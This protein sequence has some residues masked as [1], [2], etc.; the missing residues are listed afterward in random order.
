MEEPLGKVFKKIRTGKKMSLKDVSGD[1]LSVSF[2]SKFE[3]GESDITLTRF[4]ML[5]N[6]L[7]VSIEEFYKLSTNETPS[8]NEQLIGKVSQAYYNNNLLA[9]KK[10][11]DDEFV[12]YVE[13]KSKKY[14]YNSIMIESFMCSINNT[15]I[16]VESTKVL[17]DYLFGIEYWGKYELMIF[18]NAMGA[19]P[20]KILTLL[21]DELTTK[22]RLFGTVD[23]N[24]LA[25]VSI[26]INGVYACIDADELASARKYLDHLSD[27]KIPDK[28]L[29][30]KF[31]MK[32]ATGLY[33]I[34]VGKAE[35]G[36]KQIENLLTVLIIMESDQLFISREDKYKHI[37]NS[38]I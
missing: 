2:A 21:I 29:Y 37:I 38:N 14:L 1:Y 23:E 8:E 6:N 9:L 7:N 15:E 20:V 24:Y 5:L 28:L 3:R 10:Y 17:S 4:L 12:K 33:N 34:K 25:K 19:L 26:L 31:E 16:S 32:F 13:T 27:M 22:T 11:Q 18:G 35:I 30:E 36:K